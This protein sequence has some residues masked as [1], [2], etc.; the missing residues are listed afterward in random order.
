MCQLSYLFCEVC[1]ELDLN[2]IHSTIRCQKQIPCD[3][4]EWKTFVTKTTCVFCMRR[5]SDLDD[6][7][8]QRYQ[9]LIG[10]SRL[11]AF[12]ALRLVAPP[13]KKNVSLLD[14]QM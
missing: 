2:K 1:F 13:K 3:V 14:Y 12:C 4:K 10:D 6:F 7:N 11:Q 9:N 5:V 8:H